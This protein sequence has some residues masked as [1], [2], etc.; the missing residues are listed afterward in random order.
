MDEDQKSLDEANLH[1]EQIGY[2]LAFIKW[3]IVMLIMLA[4][5]LVV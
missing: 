1:L 4:V 5:I 3:G 2:H